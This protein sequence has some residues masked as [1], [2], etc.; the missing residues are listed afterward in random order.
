[1]ARAINADERLNPAQEIIEAC[2]GVSRVVEVTGYSEA[3]V[4]RWTYPEQRGGTGGRIPQKAQQRLVE[5]RARGEVD[6]D[7]VALFKVD[8]A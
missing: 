8:A 3:W 2:G 6:F 5:A 1:M 4:H 7:L